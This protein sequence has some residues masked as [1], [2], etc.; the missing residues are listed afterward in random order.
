[1]YRRG[2]RLRRLSYFYV[3]QEFRSLRTPTFFYPA[4]KEGKSAPLIGRLNPYGFQ[5][6]LAAEAMGE[7]RL[8]VVARQEVSFFLCDTQVYFIVVIMVEKG[9]FF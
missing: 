3:S 1:M 2:H 5:V 4:I 9:S 8:A 7:V 6:S